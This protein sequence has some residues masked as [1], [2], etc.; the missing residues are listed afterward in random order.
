MPKA[1]FFNIPAHGHVNPSLPLVAELVR[2]GHEA[3]YFLTESYRSKI[4]ETGAVFQPYSNLHDD[5]FDKRGLDGSRPQFA[6]STLITTADEI[7][8]ELL[9]ITRRAQ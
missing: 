2:R 5:F 3:T 4:E 7:L 9:D 8:P 1:L 6:A